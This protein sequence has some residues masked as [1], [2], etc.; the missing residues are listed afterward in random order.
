M[1]PATVSF[2]SAALVAGALTPA[3]SASTLAA[4]ARRSAR[5]PRIEARVRS[6]NSAAAA[7]MST[8]PPAATY[9]S[10]LTMP[11]VCLRDGSTPVEPWA[12]RVVER[13]PPAAHAGGDNLG[14]LTSRSVLR[15]TSAASR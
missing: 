4:R 2:D 13:G 3:S 15:P 14:R 7:A 9:G 12:G 8:S 6:A 5:A 11:S 1:S 10:V